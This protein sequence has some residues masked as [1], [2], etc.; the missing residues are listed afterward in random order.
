MSKLNSIEIEK[1]LLGFL[2][3]NG[4]NENLITNYLVPNDFADA[5]HK[6]IYTAINILLNKNVDIEL[7]TLINELKKANV[8]QKIGGEKYLIDLIRHA[9][10][11]SNITQYAIEISNFAKLRLIKQNIL[12]VEKN[13]SLKNSNVEDVISDLSNRIM[14]VSHPMASKKFQ[15]AL[16][17][18]N[19]SIK[20]LKSRATGKIVSGIETQY[21]A[22][23]S[24][25]SGFQKGDLIILAS[26]PS[27]GKTS[28]SLNLA[29]NIA[30]TKNVAFF[31]LEM[32][33]IQLINRVLSAKS[34][35]ESNRLRNARNITKLEW[36]KIY[37]FQNKIGK[38]NL[39]IDDT[40]GLTLSELVWKSKKLMMGKNRPNIIFIDYMQLIRI[41]N[42][43]KI[44]NRQAEVAMISNGLKQLARELN[45][46]I[47][48]LAQLSRRVEQRENKIPIMS[49][50]RES[51]SIEQDADLIMFLYRE[52]YYL[53]KEEVH[54]KNEQQLETV[55][56]IIA[57]HRNGETGKFKLVFHKNL[58]KFSSLPKNY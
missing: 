11:K 17:L 32:P 51:G 14:S 34:G 50:L 31:S 5:K 19:T 13:I 9:G 1:A 42:S 54:D 57:K 58:G 6:Y 36:E 24:M 20:E 45:V 2:I 52:A 49:D 3:E 30:Q 8:F 53:E 22:L 56:V 12:E 46:P 33:S 48:A 16:N 15:S 47:V 41:N 43:S 7:P 18:I 25:T 44:D 55:D 23:D 38:Y 26:R 35:I 28:L 10:L 40:P 29:V 4:A 39:F 27:M 21:Y 37:H